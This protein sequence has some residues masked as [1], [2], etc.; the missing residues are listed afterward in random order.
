V[1]VKT[2]CDPATRAIVARLGFRLISFLELPGVTAR[3][4]A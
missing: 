2:L 1:E 3:S 4:P